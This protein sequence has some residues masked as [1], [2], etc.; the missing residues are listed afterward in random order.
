[1]RE[2][3]LR[4]DDWIIIDT[5]TSGLGERD[6]VL[7]I[8]ALDG[9]GIVLLDTRVKL[10]PRKR[11]GAKSQQVHGITREDLKVAPMWSDVRKKLDMIAN[12]KECIAYNASFDRR[13]IEQTDAAHDV[14]GAKL[15]WV[16]IMP[17]YNARAIVTG[18]HQTTWAQL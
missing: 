13:I 10:P 14:H 15:A 12:G 1:M 2:F 4:K 5:E 6:V 18:K 8:A 16:D 17:V 9:N 7:E 11:I 3:G